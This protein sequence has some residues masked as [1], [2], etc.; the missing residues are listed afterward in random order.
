LEQKAE[1]KQARRLLEILSKEYPTTPEGHNAAGSLY[2]VEH[3]GKV[4]D[5]FA[6]PSLDGGRQDLK[7]FR[8]KVVLVDFWAT[9]CEPCVKELPALRALRERL[10]SRGFEIVGV[11]MDEKPETARGFLDQR[12]LDWPQMHDPPA[13]GEGARST[14]ADR[15]GIVQIPFKLLLD[16]EGR[17]VVTGHRLEDVLDAIDRELSGAQSEAADAKLKSKGE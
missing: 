16:R 6:A 12:Q 11:D 17:L 9:W 8:G 5:D 4:L 7:S 14:L 13:A 15:F 3:I 1:T 10:Q 2:R